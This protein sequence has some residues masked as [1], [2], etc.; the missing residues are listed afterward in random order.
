MRSLKLLIV[1]AV[2]ALYGC[3]APPPPHAPSSSSSSAPVA[4]VQQPVQPV[5]PAT[6]NND[7][8]SSNGIEPPKDFVA[9][10]RMAREIYDTDQERVTFYCGCKYNESN[11][12]D[13]KSCGFT[14]RKNE[15]RADRIEWEH[16]VPAYAFGSQRSCWKDGGRDLCGDKDETFA[17]AEADLHN[18]VPAIGEVNGDRSN[19]PLTVVNVRPEIAKQYGRCEM[20]IDF[21]NRKA[22]PPERARGAVGRTYLYMNDRYNLNLSTQD[23]RVY[24]EWNR[25]YPPT[26]KEKTRNQDVACKMGWGNP[27]VGAVDLQKC[28][29]ASASRR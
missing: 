25:K 22:M 24:E 23:R 9:A 8:R 3:S 10:K 27:Y 1:G 18:L 21:K 19:M 2:I 7:S 29:T 17:R 28:S 12:V 20:V 26:Q 16:I 11:E 4:P 13:E 14:P 6:S 15:K 5:K